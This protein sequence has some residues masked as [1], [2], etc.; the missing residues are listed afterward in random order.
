ML[1]AP[2]ADNPFPPPTGLVAMYEDTLDA[3]LF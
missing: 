2:W 1:L 3:V